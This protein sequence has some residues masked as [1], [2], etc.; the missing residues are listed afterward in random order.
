M[1]EK[2]V[3]LSNECEA[4]RWNPLP[5]IHSV[6]PSSYCQL[7]SNIV[8]S[9]YIALSLFS[10]SVLHT[11]HVQQLAWFWESVAPI[12][13]ATLY[14]NGVQAFVILWPNM[15]QDQG[16]QHVVAGEGAINVAWLHTLSEAKEHRGFG[17]KTLSLHL[18]AF[19]RQKSFT[20]S[21]DEPLFIIQNGFVVAIYDKERF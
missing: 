21:I 9:S 6:P 14:T 12:Y 18:Y 15:Y 2:M 5:F 1:S 20:T 10:L 4:M 19:I 8:S 13:S 17:T 11:P 7:A 3:T 16:Q